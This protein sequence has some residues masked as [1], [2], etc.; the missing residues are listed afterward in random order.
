MKIDGVDYKRLDAYDGSITIA[1][2]FVTNTNK[3]CSGHGEAKLYLGPKGE[4]R[5]FFTEDPN[6]K[7]FSAECFLLKK[8]LLKYME[9]IK[10]EYYHPSIKY[11][12]M[13]DKT[14]DQSMKKLWK[15]RNEEIKSYPNN[16]FA[17]TIK[18]Q[19]QIK[20][21]R[22]YVKTIGKDNGYDII[23]KVSLPFITNLSIMKLINEKK[24]IKFYWLLSLDYQQMNELRY[25]ALHYGEKHPK[26]LRNYRRGQAKYKEALYL[27]YKHCP[28]TGIDDIHIL[29]GSHI[30]PWYL[31]EGKEKTDPSNGFLLSPLYDKLFDKGY[32]TFD[33]DGKIRISDW[34]SEEN[35]KRISFKY[36]QDEL[37]IS[38]NTVLQGY[39]KYHRENIF[40]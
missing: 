24:E 8:D 11:K 19:N 23:R 29:I 38:G 17:F 35:K 30:K 33:N 31:C 32:I 21:D 20:G 10:Y 22:G 12:G 3:T 15:K 14:D 4:M 28:F 7:G 18:E 5:K 9:Q 25:N 36:N 16:L 13:V 2:S 1:D 27:K 6:I 37:Q 39:L 34:L 26:Q 40:K